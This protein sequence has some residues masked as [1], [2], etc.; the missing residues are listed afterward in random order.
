MNPISSLVF[1]LLLTVFPTQIFCN[2]IDQACGYTSF[3][4]LC[5]QTLTPDAE[6]LAA[7]DLKTI[8]KVALKY[9]ESDAEDLDNQI[10]K[11]MQ[12]ESNADVKRAL[13]SCSDYF[14]TVVEKI[15]AAQYSISSVSNYAQ[16]KA[17]LAEAL[18][19]IQRCDQVFA[20]KPFKSPISDSTTKLGRLES[21]AV[22]IISKL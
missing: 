12:S 17:W 2:L 22:A 14:L 21:N 6:A 15:Q 8:A 19:N 10:I 16:A 3:P 13:S 9:T 11:L 5:H 4:I 7:T 1:V 18:V 20:G